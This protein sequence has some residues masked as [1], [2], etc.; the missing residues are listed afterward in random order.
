MK[1]NIAMVVSELAEP[2]VQQVGV[3]LY[4]VEFVKEGPDYYLRV[5]IDKE[6]GVDI[7]DCEAVSRLLDPALDAADPIDVHYYLE[8]SSVG[9]DRPLKKEKDFLHFMGQLIEVK[10]F[11][12]RDGRKEFSGTLTAYNDG[13]FTLL[14]KDGSEMIINC[15][16][17]ALVRPGIEF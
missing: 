17:A 4:D 14:L 6:G 15:S 10:L 7:N 9:L 11:A 5:F 16:D 8:V 12:P 13:E 1:Q 3:T 2:L